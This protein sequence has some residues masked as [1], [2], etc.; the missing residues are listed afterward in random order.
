MSTVVHA[1][2]RG[3]SP[4]VVGRWRRP[5]GPR[6]EAWCPGALDCPCLHHT[7]PSTSL[8]L[9]FLIC[10]M[11]SSC[12]PCG[13]AVKS[14][15]PRSRCLLFTAPEPECQQETWLRERELSIS[16]LCWKKEETPGG[17]SD[18]PPGQHGAIQM[19][20]PALSMRTVSSSWRGGH[21]RWLV[22]RVS[23]SD[24]VLLTCPGQVA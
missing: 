5:R 3:D 21:E 22:V 6:R 19:L 1:H 4:Y 13:V 17:L 10:I 7:C 2:V 9:G 15:L 24:P 11:G 20:R 23:G 16:S 18:T 8:S 12:P 14:R